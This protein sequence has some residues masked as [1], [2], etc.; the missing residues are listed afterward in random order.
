MDH[1]FDYETLGQD[2]YTCPV[3]NVSFYNF[4]RA[5]FTSVM[6]PYRFSELIKDVKS[7]KFEVEDQ[8]KTYGYKIEQ[9]TLEWWSQQG[10]KARSIL[11]PSTS[12]QKLAHAV[13]Q[14]LD[15]VAGA[16]KISYW[17]SRSNTFDPIILWRTA[18][19][20]GNLARVQDLLK[21]WAVRDT[22]TFIDAKFDFK[23]KN[24]FC[25][26]TDEAKWNEVFVP[27]DS[28]HDVAAEVM[29]LQAIIRA[30]ADLDHIN[31]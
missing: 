25:P 1:I 27:H 10:A 31:D 22:R 11:K 28:T 2:V 6:E 29:R 21:Y 15:Y 12:D 20:T 3:L 14:H 26:F 17:W 16:K 24:S 19:D 7:V 30:E 18:R 4:D 23:V 9:S 13:E 8:V 5:R